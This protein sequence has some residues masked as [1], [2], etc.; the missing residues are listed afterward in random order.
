MIKLVYAFAIGISIQSLN[1]QNIGINSTGVT[2]DNS[3]ML[4]VKSTSKGMLIP[5]MTSAQ[6]IAITSPAQGLEVFDTSTVS[7]WFYN[8]TVWVELFSGGGIS[9]VTAGTG[10]TGGGTTGT[11]TLNAVGTKWIDQQCE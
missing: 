7:F 5:R 6:R 9:G 3:A 8:G 2:P 10:L 1:A 4:D 11:V